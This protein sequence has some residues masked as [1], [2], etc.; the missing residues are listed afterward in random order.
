M[1]GRRQDCV[2]QDIGREPLNDPSD[3]QQLICDLK[4]E[5]KALA[6][7]MATHMGAEERKYAVLK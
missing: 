5:G 2:E 6:T 1:Y 3:L 7:F 4:E